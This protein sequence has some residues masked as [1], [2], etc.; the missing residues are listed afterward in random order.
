MSRE[1]VAMPWVIPANGAIEAAISIAVLVIAFIGWLVQIIGQAKGAQVP[2]QNRP[3][4]AGQRPV[5]PA[6]DRPQPRRDD[7]LQNEIDAFLREVG[8]KKTG[9]REEEEVAIEILPDEE[10]APR[11][12]V[13][14][15]SSPAPPSGHVSE[16][17]REQQRRRERLQ[18]TLAERHLEATPLGQ[19]LRRHVEQ[20]ATETHQLRQE[21]EQAERRLAEAHAEIKAMRAQVA[22][23]PAAA[24]VAAGKGSA[25]FL[26]L[27]KNRKSVKEAI[28]I[29][30]V[31][32]R[33]KGLRR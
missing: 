7:R 9:R 14:A 6:M 20:F 33:P 28:V 15:G 2:P 25:R 29:N 3:R 26:S 27:L 16:W 5:A 10:E 32:G 4:P 22:A 19:D 1:A 11:R 24:P 17:D 13:P 23:S 12:L 18:S 30:E 31:L 21:K 8:A